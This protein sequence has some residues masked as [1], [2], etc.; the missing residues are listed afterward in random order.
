MSNNNDL[1]INAI[2]LPTDIFFEQHQIHQLFSSDEDTPNIVMSSSNGFYIVD[3]KSNQ[4]A[5][6]REEPIELGI[7]PDGEFKPFDLLE[8]GQRLVVKAGSTL[9]FEWAEV[10]MIATTKTLTLVAKKKAEPDLDTAVVKLSGW[11]QI[12]DSAKGWVR[13]SSLD[14]DA[15]SLRYA[16]N[17]DQFAFYSDGFLFE[18]SFLSNFFYNDFSAVATG[19]DPVF[20][21]HGTATIKNMSNI[22]RV[23]TLVPYNSGAGFISSIDENPYDLPPNVEIINGAL[24]LNLAANQDS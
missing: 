21:Q 24:V 5:T 3:P 22:D 20:Y 11:F 12:H 23:L 15:N 17:L 10:P 14:G 18:D 4:P 13:N 8:L 7:N 19:F 9:I 6:F 16:L 1:L 2:V